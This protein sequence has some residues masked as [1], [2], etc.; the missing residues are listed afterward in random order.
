MII[1]FIDETSIIEKKIY[2]SI[3]RSQLSDFEKIFLFYR[4]LTI[5]WD[6]DENVTLHDFIGKYGIFSDLQ[7]DLLFNRSHL[8]AY[9]SATPQ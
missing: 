5:D 1:K 6:V 8:K 9:E 2:I 7:E 4:G 3:I